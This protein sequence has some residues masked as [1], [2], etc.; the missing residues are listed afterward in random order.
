MFGFKKYKV[1]YCGDHYCYEGA[2]DSYKAGKKVVLYY[3]DKFIATD[4]DYSFYIDGIRIQPLHKEGKGYAI[5]FVMPAHDI[6]LLCEE[7]NSMEPP[8]TAAIILNKRGIE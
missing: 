3:K 8:D 7:R 5:K 4:T 6:S 1:D 2:K